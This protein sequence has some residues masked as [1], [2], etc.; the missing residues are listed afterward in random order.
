MKTNLFLVE[1]ENIWSSSR[2]PSSQRIFRNVS[3]ASECLHFQA[4]QAS[5]AMG[6]KDGILEMYSISDNSWVPW[7]LKNRTQV[8]ESVL[9]YI[10]THNYTEHL[11]LQDSVV[12]EH[13]KTLCFL[14]LSQRSKN[15]PKNF[16]RRGYLITQ[17][18]MIFHLIFDTPN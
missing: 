12:Y 7:I 3:N 15:R 13:E 4:H 16:K 6:V 9:V 17:D 5:T 18:T 8:S 11:T 2:L 14:Y 10:G 1:T